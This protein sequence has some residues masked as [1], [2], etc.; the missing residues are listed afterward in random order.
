MRWLIV[1]TASALLLAGC[2]GSTTVFG[3]AARLVPADAVGFIALDTQLNAGEWAAVGVLLQRFPAQDPLLVHLSRLQSMLGPEVD[4]VAIGQ[5]LVTL[6]RAHDRAKLLRQLGG[7]FSSRQVGD[8]TAFARNAHSLEAIGTAKATLANARSYQLATAS[9]PGSTVARAYANPATAR[10]L[11]DPLAGQEQVLS[12]PSPRRLLPGQPINRKITTERFAWAA[13]SLV[14]GAHGLKLAAAAQMQPQPPL[15]L[16]QAVLIE[17][18]MPVYPSRLVDE[19]PADA[20]AVAD[21]QVTESEFEPADPTTL[22]P[23]V[24]SAMAISPNLP[25]ELDTI[26]GGETAVYV[27][28]IGASPEVTLVTQPADT[29]AALEDIAKA[30]QA[31]HSLS[32]VRLHGRYSAASS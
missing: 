3:G 14:E 1:G 23:L 2:G 8:W 12:A 18:P 10:Q 29:R 11:L 15:V 7:G 30:K 31:F 25:N 21:F 4:L 28:L 27:R 17:A 32:G 16:E 20:L 9:L 6:T 19:I 13:A 26:L 24:R 5:S 22:P